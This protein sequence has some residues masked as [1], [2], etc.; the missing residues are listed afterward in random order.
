MKKLFAATSI[1]LVF[2]ILLVACS[3][4]GVKSQST[5]IAI[6]KFVASGSASVSR[7]I[8]SGKVIA[9]FHKKAGGEDSVITA[10]CG[11]LIS[12]HEYLCLDLSADDYTT[13]LIG[14]SLF[15]SSDPR[16]KTTLYATAFLTQATMEYCVNLSPYKQS[17]YDVFESVSINLTFDREECSGR[18]Y[19]EKCYLSEYLSD[20]NL[21]SGL[22]ASD[23]DSQ[24]QSESWQSASSGISAPDESGQSSSQN[25]SSGS[26]SQQ[27]SPSQSASQSVSQSASDSSST[28]VQV[29]YM[30]QKYSEYFPIGYAIGADHIDRYKGNLDRHFNSFTCENEMKMYTIAPNSPTDDYFGQ[31]DAMISYV[32]SQGKV[33]RGHALIWHQGAPGWITGIRDKNQLLSAI[34][35]YVTRVVRH[36]GDKVYCWDVVNEAV[37]DDNRYRS[38]FYDVAGIDFIKTAFRAARNANPNIKLFYNDYNMDNPNK[39]AKVMEMLRELQ[40]DGVPIDGVGMQAHYNLKDTYIGNV[41]AA[42][43]DFASLGLEVQ[44]T[45]L[46]VKNYGNADPQGQA[47]LYGKLFELFRKYKGTITGV[48]FWNVADDYSWLDGNLFSYYGTGKAYPTLFD[49]NHNKK[50]AFFKVFDF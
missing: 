14:L 16:I 24:S 36:Y 49:E 6:K 21:L 50:S 48:T 29:D 9:N 33:V 46:D 28:P 34:E 42:I 15:S 32:R 30:W 27:A 20:G 25:Q 41:E 38:T 7:N 3:L 12:T 4:G 2:S 31:S 18:V 40:R 13:V 43:K 45:E 23:D 19:V 11:Y 35:Q 10:E 1:L 44:I 47:N 8:A 22:S 17:G 5:D 37:G 39:R 26:A